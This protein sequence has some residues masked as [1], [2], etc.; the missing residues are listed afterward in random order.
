M[1]E[2]YFMRLNKFEKIEVHNTI[3]MQLYTDL[4]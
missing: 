1:T 3:Q 4:N 2:I